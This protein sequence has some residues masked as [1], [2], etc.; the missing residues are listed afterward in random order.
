VLPGV[1]DAVSGYSG[2]SKGHPN[3]SPGDR[4]WKTAISRALR[5]ARD[6]PI[7][8]SHPLRAVLAQTSILDGGGQVLLDRGASYRR[9]SSPDGHH[10]SRS[11]PSPPCSSG[12]GTGPEKQPR[13]GA[14]PTG[15]ASSGQPR[16]ITR[17]TPAKTSSNTTI[18]AGHA[19]AISGSIRSGLK[20]RNSVPWPEQKSGRL[21]RVKQPLAERITDSLHGQRV[22][23]LACSGP[24]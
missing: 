13:Y 4:R 6:R 10:V 20:A 3:L 23:F 11:R 2:G 1:V 24:A 5:G 12:Q 7:S 19:D 22:P 18:T 14:D 16:P 15:S 21:P 8:Y 17:T 9:R